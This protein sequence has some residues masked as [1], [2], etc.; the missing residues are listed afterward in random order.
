LRNGI[1]S[2]GVRQSRS[3]KE[4]RQRLTGT[5]AVTAQQ[6]AAVSPQSVQEIRKWQEC[7]PTRRWRRD[8]DHSAVWDR[9]DAGRI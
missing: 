4:K 3:P 7:H 6:Q 8:S 5:S 2:V 9:A 1:D